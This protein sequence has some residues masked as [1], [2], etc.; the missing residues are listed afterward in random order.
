MM[1]GRFTGI[2][3][4]FTAFVGTFKTWAIAR[5]EADEQKIKDLFE[6]IAELDKKIQDIT[7]AL[8]AIG[9]GLALT[10]PITGIL[11]LLFLPALPWILVCDV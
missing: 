2:T 8:I 5:E 3:D 1:E 9:S 10:L 11:A 4:D 6:E 7:I